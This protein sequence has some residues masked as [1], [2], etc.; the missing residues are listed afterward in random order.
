MLPSERWSLTPPF[1]LFHGPNT[2]NCGSLIFCCTFCKPNIILDSPPVRWHGALCCP[3][4]PPR[5][6]H[7]GDNL[8]C[9]VQRYAI[10]YKSALPNLTQSLRVIL[11]CLAQIESTENMLCPFFSVLSFFPR[12][13]RL[14]V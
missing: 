3:D 7:Q 2:L 4:F 1:H 9:T 14:C 12:P 8:F 6:F 13:L 11:N 10:E 5:I